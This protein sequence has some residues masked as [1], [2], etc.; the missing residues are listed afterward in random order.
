MSASG[1]APHPSPPPWRGEG[2]E[3]K[4]VLGLG[5]II[6]MNV[7]AVVGLRWITRGA[8]VDAPAVTLW[9]LAWAMFFVPLAA[10]VSEL[11]SRYPEQ[12][13]IYAW[14]RRA[15]GP[16]HGFICGWCLWVNNLF[17]FPSALLFAAANAAAIFGP[18][19]AAMAETRW[20]SMVF[21]LGVLWMLVILNIRGWGAG[22]WLQ[23]LGGIS[24][25]IPAALLIAAGAVSLWLYGSATSFAP[26]NLLPREDVMTTLSLWSA[27]CFA[28][29]GFEIGSFSGQEVK[30][31]RRTIPRG[32]MIAGLITTL[33]YIIGTVSVLVA[34]PSSAVAERSGVTEVVD[35][36]SSR[37][38]LVGLG[39]L[40]GAL[41]A[42]GQV[43]GV[44]AW[45]SGAARV[46]FAAGLDRVM[47]EAMARLHPKHQT[48]H[49]ALI[50]QAIISS[51]I[52][53]VSLFF[54][55]A[56]GQTTIQEAYDILVNLTIIIYFIPY[57]YLFPALVKLRRIDPVRAG[58]EAMLVPGGRI[59]L[60][61]I[62]A[63]GSL[64][65]LI[66]LALVFIPPAG[67][68]STLNYEANLILQSLI[69][70]AAGCI[71]YWV[72]RR[73]R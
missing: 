3:L 67:T 6:L 51:L 36:V 25:W 23:N 55:I 59:G 47:P 58:D 63:A 37:I 53:L 31:P 14:S 69:V 26:S 13:G 21:V 65:T 68:T 73:H 71:L 35:L 52:L 49:V 48:P 11:S 2:V 29:S 57:L 18:Q 4:R 54:T 62:A 70:M 46:G 60:W 17:Y 1:P 34:V 45:A 56:G 12:G 61:T 41:I 10:A 16:V 22:R 5:D 32:V 44:S 64:A 24:T 30:N 7:V 39:V 20:F 27:M 28:F 33:I 8:R 43:A 50:V 40:T 9:I 38:G 15:F 19:G 66:S 42:I 72:S